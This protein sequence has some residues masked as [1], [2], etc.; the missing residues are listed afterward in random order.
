LMFVN[1]RA[2]AIVLGAPVLIVRFLMMA[3]NWGQ[4]AFIDPA[5]PELA[6]VN[7]CNVL[8]KRYNRRCFNDGY[9]I[10]HHIVA[11]RHWT[12]MPGDYELNKPSYAREG[13]LVFR[14]VDFVGVWFLLMLH[15]YDA[16]ARQVVQLGD[17]PMSQEELV[18]LIK[19]RLVAIP[20]QQPAQ[21]PAVAAA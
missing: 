16:L 11:T 5:R 12:E 18:A 9:H 10:G 15:R 20:M 4:H 2:T 8:H 19:S 6:Y 14:D 3:G 7:S 1:W 21:S 13:A 17:Q